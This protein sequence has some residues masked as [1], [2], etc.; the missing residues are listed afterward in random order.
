[1][2][3]SKE[4]KYLEMFYA[5][6]FE[7]N[8]ELNK[9]FTYLEKNP[10]DS[11]TLESIFRVTHTV[12]GN[13]MA[14][15]LEGIG[16]LSH[17]LEELFIKIRESDFQPNKG[18]FELI[19]RA[20]D[21]LGEMI[22]AIK[23][24][25]EVTYQGLMAKI[26][27]YQEKH[28]QSGDETN[29]G[30]DTIPEQV[31]HVAENELPKTS[32]AVPIE[33]VESVEEPSE[34]TAINFSDQVQIP[35]KKLDGLLNLV[36][37]LIIE[38]DTIIARNQANNNEYKRLHRIT[39]DMQYAI[40]DIRLVQVGLLFNKFHRISRDVATVENKQVDLVLEG[41]E[42]EIDRN[43]LKT[44]SDS[45][46]HLVRNAISHGVET[47][48]DR[49]AK[50]KSETGSL[51]LKASNEKDT[52][53][54]QVVDDG[55]GIDPE[56]IKEKAIEKGLISPEYAHT[57]S[58]KE[59]INLVFESG[60]SNAEVVNEISGRGVGMDVVKRSTE[61]IGGQVTIESEVGKG[62]T[63]TMKLPSSMA[64]K[65][66]L[67]FVQSEQEYAVPL[68]YTE[69]VVSVQ[70]S[71]IHRVGKGLVTDYLGKSIPLLFLKDAFGVSSMMGLLEK[72]RLQQTYNMVEGNL[73]D[74][75]VII[76][77]HNDKYLGIAV[78]KLLQ[79]KEIVEKPL[80]KPL[81][82]VELFSGATILGNGNVCL[83]LNVSSIVEYVYA[84]KRSSQ[85]NK[86]AEVG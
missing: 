9:L 59:V 39:S 41:T 26:E 74:I 37:E 21:K 30:S 31:E 14:I 64:V 42:I 23:S 53:L 12:K 56:V 36:G 33:E 62:T 67:L 68:S 85:M 65:G 34:S 77:H 38:K 32:V 86:Y 60:F 70:A 52:V 83:V 19:F 13:A 15:G 43:I 81:D 84:E 6:A 7:S 73:K 8:E 51:T 24:G 2:F 46:V 25:K 35:I 75:N 80:S 58:E 72:G 61:S 63:F 69:A 3:K 40:M 44:I 4:K 11:E 5:E 45:L 82:R 50:G 47:P 27:L 22:Q 66:A 76:M 78:D 79:Q 10:S 48:A 49:V 1:M 54:I 71:S 18:F 57:L 55:N 28:F 17:S 16:Q 20:N 29:A